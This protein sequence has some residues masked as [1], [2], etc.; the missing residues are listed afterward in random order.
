VKSVKKV[1]KKFVEIEG[2]KYEIKEEPL[3]ETPPAP[4]TPPEGTPPEGTPPEG[5]PPETE[6]AKVEEEAKALA[7]RIGKRIKEIMAETKISDE[8]KEKAKQLLNKATGSG[9]KIKLYTTRKGKVVELDKEAA[10]DLGKW[11]Q[12]FLRKDDK[13]IREY[14]QKWEPLNEATA[15]EGGNLVPTL[16]YNV[17]VDL[18]EDV[19]VIK[20]NASVID[21][22]GMKTNQLNIDAIATKPIVQ[23]GSEQGQKATSSMTFSQISLTPYKLAAIVPITTELLQDSPF[24]VVQIVSKALG[25]AVAKAEDQAFMNGSGTG[26]PTGLST[27]TMGS[28]IS[29][30]NALT[31]DHIVSAFWR[32]P[33]A[34]RNRASWLMNGRTIANVSNMK[35]SQNRPLLLD[36][37]IITEPGIPALKGR[38]VLEQN[39]LA[40]ATILF[41][42]LSAYYIGMKLPMTIS[43]ADQ[44]VIAGYSLWERNMIAVRVEERIDGELANTRAFVAITNTGVA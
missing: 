30:G 29:A 6:E 40:A 1:V 9:E 38:P 44:A 37:G 31:F 11:F 39:D 23:W 25:E 33:S 16:L 4:P 43:V 35:D 8:A 41:G 18:V 34:Y 5:T 2:K 10:G 36:S 12:A 22:T 3:E 14:Y 15:A 17:L 26:R 13:G 27:Y 19:A 32:L 20:P 21:M 28:T 7:E 24:N 42:D